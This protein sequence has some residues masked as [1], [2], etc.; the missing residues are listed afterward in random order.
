LAQWY[1]QISDIYSSS[2]HFIFGIPHF[3]FSRP[4]IFPLWAQSPLSARFRPPAALRAPAACLP[5]GVSLPAPRI[6]A[7]CTATTMDRRGLRIATRCVRLLKYVRRVTKLGLHRLVLKMLLS[8]AHS[9]HLSGHFR[10]SVNA[11]VRLISLFS[12][13]F[14]ETINFCHPLEVIYACTGLGGW[15]KLYVELGFLDSHGRSDLSAY[16]SLYLF[17]F[18][19]CLFLR[20]ADASCRGQSLEF[21][22]VLVSHTMYL[23]LVFV[24]NSDRRLRLLPRADNARQALAAHSRVSA[25][26]L[27]VRRCLVFLP[28]RVS[29]LRASGRGAERHPAL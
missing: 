29:A 9:R 6:G 13:G 1:R 17:L 11:C 23:C 16:F 7:C 15:P 3:P 27:G 2:I 12:Q 26:R 4:T 21:V 25:A 5:S 24:T 14:E 28:R 10:D 8:L 19:R 22:S 18:S 20:S